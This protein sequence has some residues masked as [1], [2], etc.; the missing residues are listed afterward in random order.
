[1]ELESLF[2][3]PAAEALGVAQV[4][5]QVRAITPAVRPA[6][7]RDTGKTISYLYEDHRIFEGADRFAG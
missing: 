2:A 1:L 4:N 6:I 5:A 7:D 3:R